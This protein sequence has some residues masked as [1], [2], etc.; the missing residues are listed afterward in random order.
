L[1]FKLQLLN[2]ETNLQEYSYIADLAASASLLPKKV[3]FHCATASK[4]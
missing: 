2:A 4:L 3:L 1:G